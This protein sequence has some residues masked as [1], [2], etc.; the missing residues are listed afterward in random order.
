MAT[1][2]L[3]KTTWAEIYNAPH[4]TLKEAKEAILATWGTPVPICLVGEAGIGK[5]QVGRQAMAEYAKM[6]D[7]KPEEYAEVYW[8]LSLK[9]PEDINGL[10]YFPEDKTEVFR[11][12]HNEELVE[13]FKRPHGIVIIDEPNRAKDPSLINSFFALITE[14]EVNG[15]KIPDGWTI[16]CMINPGTGAYN[17]SSLEADPAFRRRLSF[18]Q[19]GYSLPVFQAYM[20]SASG[21][22]KFHPQVVSFLTSNTDYCYDAA[23]QDG[24]KIGPTPASW[25]S[26][27][28]KLFALEKSGT[29]ITKNLVKI[30]LGGLVGAE[31]ASVFSKEYV[32]SSSKKAEKPKVSAIATRL[33]IDKKMQAYISEMAG[34]LNGVELPNFETTEE[35][36]E[37]VDSL[38]KTGD[39]AGW[40]F[41]AINNICSY[42]CITPSEKIKQD[43]GKKALKKAKELYEKD[44]EDSDA[45]KVSLPTILR[46]HTG[47][48]EASKK[49]MED[50]EYL[51]VVILIWENFRVLFDLLPEDRRKILV[52]RIQESII[53]LEDH[54][55]DM[56]EQFMRSSNMFVVLANGY[57]PF[58]ELV[59][60][61]YGI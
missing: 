38:Q 5:T 18:I 3:V 34:N 48:A 54:Q 10:A 55:E 60:E 21:Q 47:G 17:V 35:F 32:P 50:I 20:M 4:A 31:I 23:L 46:S 1:N 56:P 22:K 8:Q 49:I 16:L 59:K 33:F 14:R 61:H 36:Q 11:T 51:Q 26:C 27:S 30:I 7:L 44:W 2:E 53:G 37:Y 19:V 13:A 12:M 57:E 28:Q 15:L 58:V 29:K 25:E 41:Q 42:I 45:F 6:K 43:A 40:L 9:C 39:D 52:S 24:N